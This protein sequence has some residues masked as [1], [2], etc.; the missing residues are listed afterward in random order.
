M[1]TEN[2]I[3]WVLRAPWL[4]L[5]AVARGLRIVGIFLHRGPGYFCWVL[6]C[7]EPAWPGCHATKETGNGRMCREHCGSRS[8]HSRHDTGCDKP[9][10]AL[11]MWLYPELYPD[12]RAAA[13]E[14]TSRLHLVAPQERN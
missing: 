12:S 1:S 6:D 2:A 3:P 14:R 7:W 9:P 4:A 5:M 8:Y 13:T 10:T 11:D